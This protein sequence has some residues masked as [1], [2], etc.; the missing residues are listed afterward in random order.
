MRRLERIECGL[1]ATVGRC[2]NRLVIDFRILGSLE[3]WDRGRLVEVR[4]T[5]Q[6][7]L[8]AMLLLRPREVRST[9]TLVDGLWGES[10]PRTS[11]PALRNYVSQLRGLIGS[12]IL[13]TRHGGYVLDIADDQIDLG[14]FQ[15]RVAEG[16]AAV[17][18]DG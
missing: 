3:I 15:A 1:F 13:L 10:A 2:Y 17:H 4:R 11:R 5:K 8:L 14:R 16:R 12:E 9:D 18:G 6:R 7:A